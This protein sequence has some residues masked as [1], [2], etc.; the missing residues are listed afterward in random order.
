MK[1][2]VEYKPCI[3]TLESSEYTYINFNPYGPACFID[4]KCI[5]DKGFYISEDYRFV[6]SR[7]NGYIYPRI[8]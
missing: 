8:E 4:G 6:Y 3:G 7:Y 2:Y 5:N 1:L